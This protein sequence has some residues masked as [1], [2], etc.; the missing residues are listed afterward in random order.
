[1]TEKQLKEME[2]AM[3]GQIEGIRVEF[4][5]DGISVGEELA[6]AEVA[7]YAESLATELEQEY[8]GAEIEV[9]ES[10]NDRIRVHAA[11]DYTLEMD[12]EA[13]V[14]Q[15]LHDHWQTWIDKTAAAR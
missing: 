10:I 12:T 4:S 9:E 5:V 15:L 13:D 3:D 14:Q 8:P 7:D 1:M 2:E 11:D 6:R